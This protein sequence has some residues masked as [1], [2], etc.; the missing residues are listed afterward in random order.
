MPQSGL[1]VL[2]VFIL[3]AHVANKCT[4]GVVGHRAGDNALSLMASCAGFKIMVIVVAGAVCII[5]DLPVAEPSL[6]G[7]STNTPNMHH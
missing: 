3:R 5:Y 4:I 6:R 2:I 7:V 1:R